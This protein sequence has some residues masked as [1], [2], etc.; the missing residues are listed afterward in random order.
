VTVTVEG[1]FSV[2]TIMGGHYSETFTDA[3]GRYVVAH[4]RAGD[5]Q[6]CAGGSYMGGMLGGDAL[7]G[8]TAIGGVRVSE[9]RA[10]DGVD[11]RLEAP[12]KLEI[13]ARD[14]DGRPVPGAALFV[15]DSEGRPLERFS[16]NTTGPDGRQIC[17]GIAPGRYTVSA[18]TGALASAE[19]TAVRVRADETA[20]AE[21]TLVAGTLL[22]IEVVEKSDELVRARIRVTDSQGREV[23]GLLALEDI[24]RGGGDFQPGVQTVGP[25][26]PGD[27][28]VSAVAPDGTDASKP[29]SLSGQPERSVKLRLK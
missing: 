6:V 12:C 17:G 1:G 9:G 20:L 18:R 26:P 11:F 7:G 3:D 4:L 8:R 10:R 13:L 27:Y 28:K 15:R 23:S 14:A 25:L 29:V 22:R 24:T 5:Y 19:S 21:V 16:I 2:G